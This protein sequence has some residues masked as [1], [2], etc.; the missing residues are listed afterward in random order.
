MG[1]HLGFG[2]TTCTTDGAGHPWYVCAFFFTE[3]CLFSNKHIYRSLGVF[4]FQNVIFRGVFCHSL[5]KNRAPR[6]LL[7]Q[8]NQV[9]Q[10]SPLVQHHRLG[11]CKLRSLVG[12]T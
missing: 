8:A 6:H 12:M 1:E 11:V 5:N 2:V 9:W 10:P 7:S 4:S 3:G